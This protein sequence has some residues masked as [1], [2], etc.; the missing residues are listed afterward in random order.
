MIWTKPSNWRIACF[1]CPTGRP[2]SLLEK[3]LPPPRGKR[4]KDVVA[5][6]SEEMRIVGGTG[7]GRHRRRLTHELRSQQPALDRKAHEFGRRA[8]AKLLANDGRGIGDRLVGRMHQPCDLG[9]AFSGAEQPQYL[10]LARAVSFDKT[11]SRANPQDRQRRCFV[12]SPAADKLLP[13][14]TSRMASTRS[15]GSPDFET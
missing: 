2:A 12:R 4:S 3:S 6:I 14:P 9:E 15:Q 11:G 13:S 8:Q 1:C 7:C 5:S 10:D